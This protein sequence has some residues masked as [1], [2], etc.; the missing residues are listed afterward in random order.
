MPEIPDDA[1]V[2]P[3]VLDVE[4]R[5]AGPDG[6]DRMNFYAA[7]DF[8]QNGLRATRLNVDEITERLP[9]WAA[10]ARFREQLYNY[11]APGAKKGYKNLVT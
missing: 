10:S 5:G 4:R 7:A 9:Q 8:R 11:L 2:R 1:I 6:R 3:D